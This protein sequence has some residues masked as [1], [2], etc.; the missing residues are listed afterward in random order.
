VSIGHAHF[1]LG[2]LVDSAQTYAAAAARAQQ[3]G[4]KAAQMHALT[5]AMYP[6]G[7]IRPVEGVAALDEAVEI[8]VS[9]NDPARLALT[10]MLASGFRLVFD[11]WSEA[12][13]E[14][15]KSAYE[16]FLRL[17]PTDLDPYQRI[18]YAHILMLNGKYAEAL[19]L[20]DRSV[21]EASSLG[22]GQVVNFLAHF[23]AL[24]ANLIIFLRT[25]QFG[26]VLQI[27][28]A[29]RTSPDQNLSLY[30]LLTLRE[31]MLRATVFDFEGARQICQEA[32]NVRGGE[33]PDAQ[34][35][36]IDEIAAGNI[37]L[38]QGK[39]SEAVEHFTRIQD[40]DEHTK[41]FMHWEWRMTAQLE[42]S[43]AWL[44]SANVVNARTA[45]EGVLKTALATSDPHLQALAWDLQARVALAENDLPAATASISKAFAIID[46]SEIQGAA[47]Q[48][49]ATASL[50]YQRLGQ[51]AAAETFRNRARSSI[52][53]IADS[54]AP[55]E[56]LRATFLTSDPVRRA[57]AAPRGKG[58]SARR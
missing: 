2:A 32:R 12:Q 57:C 44:L 22:V 58:T 24:S 30:W 20:C 23:G 49:C 1:A 7:F 36:A 34:Y 25:G 15:C 46:N 43:N 26:K 19:D 55:D 4:L 5:C 33:F 9:C 37:A 18:V 16:T 13:S 56:P 31:A 47:W 21:S 11:A 52:N 50:I 29:G 39:H 51:S 41:F 6:L 28:N 42:L 14:L 27:T 45:A 35:L 17:S 54:F 38:Q 48:T 10:Q 3:A 40:L 8:S 53:K